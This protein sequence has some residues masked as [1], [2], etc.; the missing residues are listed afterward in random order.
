MDAETELAQFFGAVKQEG[1]A[2]KRRR[3]KGGYRETRDYPRDQFQ[4]TPHRESSLVISLARQ[5]V[6]QEEEIKVLRQDDALIFFMK[7]PRNK[8][9][10][11]GGSRANNLSR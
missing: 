6:R 7:S 4:E 5:L 2:P 8:P 9:R 11:Q 1:N 3:P 10:I